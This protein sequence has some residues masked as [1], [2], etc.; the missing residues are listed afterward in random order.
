VLLAIVWGMVPL[1]AR[2]G[3]RAGALIVIACTALAAAAC[4]S[5]SP[6]SSSSSSS[7]AKA[8]AK[9]GTANVAYA[10]SL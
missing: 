1:S 5:S 7:T 8:A 3:A 9:S 2:H 6:S 4:G 10:S